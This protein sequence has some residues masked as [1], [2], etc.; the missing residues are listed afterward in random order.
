VTVAPER[1][2]VVPFLAILKSPTT[3]DVTAA[4]VESRTGPTSI[5][6]AVDC[7]ISCILAIRSANKTATAIS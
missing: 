7:F 4:P 1:T 2:A 5:V 6:V 3:A